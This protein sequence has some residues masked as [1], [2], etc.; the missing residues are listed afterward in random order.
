LT[1]LDFGN[2]GEESRN[3]DFNMD[4]LKKEMF[5][6]SLSEFLVFQ[7][8]GALRGQAPWELGSSP[9]LIIARV[10]PG[11]VSTISCSLLSLYILNL[12]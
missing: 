10:S 9:S 2:L 11:I 1:V 5:R 12:I 7:I 3:D 6:K 4:L 8:S